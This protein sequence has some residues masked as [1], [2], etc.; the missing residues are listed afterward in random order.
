M[1]D[2]SDPQMGELI[3]MEADMNP[4]DV[5]ADFEKD[6]C[7][8]TGAK[9]A[10]ATN[11]CTNALLICM[12]HQKSMEESFRPTISIP[13]RTYVGVP[14]AARLA[15]YDIQ[16]DNREWD[17]MYRLKPYPIFDSARW[18]F[19]DMYSGLRGDFVC[20]SFHWTK[21]L[22][23]GHGGAILHN[24]DEADHI[25]RRMRFDGRSEGVRPKDDTFPVLGVHA[26]ML[27][28]VA[29]DGRVRLG[30][31]SYDNDPLPNSDYPDLSKYRV[32][33]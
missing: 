7:A 20:L 18:L 10:V 23:L 6:L 9:Y 4:Y 17:G 3:Q 16:F 21:H 8:Y 27:P 31:L 26:P 15:G 28:S 30:L 22:K 1:T 19:K 32:F 11:S 33:G 12:L 29:A 24:S 13:K 25:L 2:L 5:I 14:M